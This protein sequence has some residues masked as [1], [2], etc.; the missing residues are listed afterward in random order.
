MRNILLGRQVVS[1]WGCK[2]AHISVLTQTWGLGFSS[3][4]FPSTAS[5]GESLQG[6][7]FLMARD[8]A[9]L[10]E[11]RPVN[12]ARRCRKGQNKDVTTGWQGG[13]HRTALA[14]PALA[15][16]RINLFICS[17]T[18]SFSPSTNV[19]WT[20]NICVKWHG[21]RSWLLPFPPG[22]SALRPGHSLTF[23]GWTRGAALG[24]AFRDSSPAASTVH[25][26]SQNTPTEAS[27]PP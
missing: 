23:A 14:N 17:I 8:A 10:Q 21:A 5:F 16:F 22:T 7:G 19:S 6:S 26:Q 11:W 3:S 15:W 20:L 12:E 27:D 13:P 24:P 25:L 18:H 1:S 9:S 2:G 4:G